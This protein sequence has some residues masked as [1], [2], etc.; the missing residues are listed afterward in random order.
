VSE[1][2]LA[3]HKKMICAQWCQVRRQRNAAQANTKRVSVARAVS[4]WVVGG[5]GEVGELVG[6]LDRSV[7]GCSHHRAFIGGTGSGIIRF[8]AVGFH[9][10]SGHAESFREGH[11]TSAFFHHD[12]TGWRSCG[13]WAQG[14][15]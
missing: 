9:L 2:I 3:F 15:W 11:R 4:A 7:L 10:F 5:R 14:G 13:W 8:N 6:E 12:E 1:Y